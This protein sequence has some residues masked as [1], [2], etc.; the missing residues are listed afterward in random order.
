MLFLSRIS[1]DFA[2]L[3]DAKAILFMFCRG[4]VIF[5]YKML[6]RLAEV[7]FINR[8]AYKPSWFNSLSAFLRDIARLLAFSLDNFV[9]ELN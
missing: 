7:S 8:M 6:N 2:T 3:L 1:C 5:I 9:L 4:N